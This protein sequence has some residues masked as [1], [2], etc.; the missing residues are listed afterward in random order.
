MHVLVIV[1][2]QS[3]SVNLTKND[4]HVTKLSSRTMILY[5]TCTQD[6]DYE[7]CNDFAKEQHV[8]ITVKITS[9]LE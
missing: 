6:I 7:I 2:Q 3:V 4:V 5:V 1:R 9:T 8:K